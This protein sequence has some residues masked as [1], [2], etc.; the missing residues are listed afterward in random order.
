MLVPFD[1]PEPIASNARVVT[2][3]RQ[4]GLARLAQIFTS[5]HAMCGVGVAIDARMDL[6]PHQIEPALAVLAGQRRVLIADEV[7]LGKTVQA[8]LILAELQRRRPPLR[9][10]IVTPATL[11][12]QWA[13]ELRSRFSLDVQSA[14]R[15][16]PL[17][18]ER[19][20]PVGSSPWHRPGVWI[21]SIDYL[22]QRHV[23]NGLPVAAWD[24]VVIDEA[25]V[26]AG[27]SDRHD[28]CDELGRRARHLV[29]LSATPHSGDDARFVRLLRLG[30][31]PSGSDT[32][33]VF[34]RTREDAVLPRSRVVRWHKVRPSSEGARVLD[35]LQEFERAI[36]RC[37]R[38]TRHDAALL[39]LSVLRKRALST[40]AALDRSL[41]RRAN[42]LD[43]AVK[44]D[45]V[46][47][48]QPRLDFGAVDDMDD[49]ERAALI[50]DVG[51][52]AGQERTWLR[53]LRTL[54]GAAKQHEAK[55]DHLCGLAARTSEPFIVFTEFRHSLEHI[56]HV[57]TSIRSVA[58]LH[59]GQTDIVRQRELS[60]FLDGDA[61]VLVTTD[62]GGQG[63]NLQARARWVV[64]IEL[65]WN[66][67]RLEQRIGRVDRIGQSRRVHGTLFVTA[68]PTE[69]RLL[70]SLA[71][72]TLAV[73]RSIDESTLADVTPPAHLAVAAALIGNS[74]L[75]ESPAVARPVP[76]STVHRRTAR[77]FVRVAA[78]RRALMHAWHGPTDIGTRPVFSRALPW[79]VLPATARGVL[80]F[81]VPILDRTG[82]VVEQRLVA[83]ATPACPR[84]LLSSHDARRAIDAL[85]LR[86]MH[87]RLARLRRV[88][89]AAARRR[90]ETERAIALHLHALRYPE[91]AQL[92]LFSQREAVAFNQ[93]RARAALGDTEAAA[94]L[95]AEDDRAHLDLAYPTLEWIGVKR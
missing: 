83:L 46:D 37:A 27:R 15:D 69:D 41:A 2:V 43:S 73:R 3:R 53:R 18:M 47:W 11:C 49:D 79:H 92:G 19:A 35:T 6:W 86:R 51:M 21:A 32:L 12:D 40:M 22:K 60:R 23:M 13:H 63:L 10:L 62:V 42:W 87:A 48:Y 77:A 25:H 56:Q 55:I 17:T 24:V 58:V 30:A 39:L 93:A 80:V 66:P 64:N 31:L 61:S 9:A 94:R 26:A 5:A 52:P 59:G 84:R 85:V 72:R 7:G 91:E 45:A 33:E 54:A 68:H 16:L 95:R 71:R 4:H 82:D 50:A 34:R 78:K 81:A 1:R 76:L 65:P 20:T 38:A 29:L 89:S 36:L 14:E 88:A 75:P 8:G 74:A 70:T 44:G 57:L 90:T 28:A 67:A